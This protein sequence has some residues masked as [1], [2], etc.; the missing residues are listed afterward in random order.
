[1]S[2]P[3]ALVP[4]RSSGLRF[5]TAGGAPRWWLRGLSIY[6]P[7]GASPS[8]QGWRLRSGTYPCPALGPGSLGPSLFGTIHFIFN[9]YE[10]YYILAPP[11]S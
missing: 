2:S 8:A 6:S 3:N 5:A 11:H 7:P 4:V 9:I 10:F 1:M